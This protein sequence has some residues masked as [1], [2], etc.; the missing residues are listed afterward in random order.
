L[1]N[2]AQRPAVIG[3]EDEEGK[4]LFPASGELDPDIIA[5]ALAT[6]LAE[7]SGDRAAR[8]EQRA[9]LL[10]GVGQRPP[11]PAPPRRPNFCSGCPHNRSTLLLPGQVAGGGIGCHG[12][13][14]MLKEINRGYEFITHMGGE[15]APWIGMA[16][17][18][19]RQHIFQNIGDGTFAHSGQL[20]INACVAA[21]V[22]ITYKI[23]YNRA[24]AMTGGQ[25]AAGALTVP[26]L[27]RK[28]EA[29][30]VKRT[31]VLAE[32]P[33]IYEGVELARNAS[34]GDRR[35]LEA[36]LAEMEKIPG[37]TAIIYDQRCAAEKRRLRA[38]GKLEEP[39]RRLVIHEEVCEGCGDCVKQS[40]CLSL[41]PVDT[42]LGQKMRIHQS[43][44]N[45]DYSCALGDCP[46]FVTVYLHPGAGQRRRQAADL[47]P[48]EI[49]PPKRRAAI[50][51][52]GYRILAPGIG[53]TGVVTVNAVLATAALLDGLHVMTLDQ[54]GL[55]Q[56]G[57]AVVSHLILSEKPLAAA[58]KI[59]AGNA[60][61]LLGFDLLGAAA[62]ENLR[63]AH[64]ERTVAVIN[65][66]EIPS[67]D[68]IRA[69]RTLAGPQLLVD[70]ID[71]CTRRGYNI[72]LD[73]NRVAE[74]LFGTHLAAN[75]F[76]TGA[77]WQAGLLPVSADA[78][79]RAIRLN[80][81]DAE[82]NLRVFR[83]GRKYYEEAA[84]VEKFLRGTKTKPEAV[85]DVVEDRCSRLKAYQ[86]RRTAAKFRAWVEQIAERQ[87]ALRDAVAR[88][89]Y[90]L[91]A[92]K[93]EYEV[94]RL[95]TSPAFER[96]L[97]EQWESIARIEYNLH[98]P[99]LR[100][101][102]WKK[103][104][105]LGP[106]FRYFLKVLAAFKWLRG[107]P[108]DIFGYSSLRRLERSLP[109]WYRRIVEEALDLAG[110]DNLAAVEEIA[111]LPG[112][113]RGYENIRRTSIAAA[114]KRAE[115]KLEA[116]RATA[117]PPVLATQE[118]VG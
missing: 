112:D 76:L 18:V 7:R 79:E 48:V 20:A 35:E 41:Y 36:V 89:L 42:E 17:F 73:A 13:G 108:L 19:E 30:G 39:A 45:K 1:Y 83:W 56:K 90:K 96:Q 67:G 63:T 6:R 59:N 98:P 3:K 91:I 80:G 31:V 107:T 14:M 47:P 99:L 66:A 21:G 29:E 25:D 10:R 101:W 54:T 26:A 92:N 46:S 50:P 78:V 32:D 33:R 84:W 95:L 5:R 113:I 114:Q 74:D 117:Q 51:P 110:P 40:N 82:R 44:C 34:V 75:L 4:P 85:W 105:R 61:L 2:Q 109:A 69:R 38:R 16:P 11:S 62:G 37:V 53:G 49:D 27:T 104:L 103:K 58:A 60:D 72:Y 71:A 77:A 118:D 116:L 102:G 28:L 81:V 106:G 68:A 70:Q 115:E 100:A 52:E 24:V 57:G 111:A 87:P 93:D 8:M 86:N 65:T 64:P 12:M 15:G 22:N 88:H 9:E 94:A 55:A 97:E 43:S 23:L